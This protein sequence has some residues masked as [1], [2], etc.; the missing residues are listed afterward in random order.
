MTVRVILVADGDTDYA[1]M[2]KAKAEDTD[3]SSLPL[4]FLRPEAVGLRRRA[5]GG[6]NTLIREAGLAAIMAAKGHAD[7]VMVL[8]DNDGDSR[9]SFPH[10]NGCPGCRECDARNALERIYWGPPFKRAAA[11]VFQ[12]AETLLLSARSGFTPQIEA[13]C[14]GKRLKTLLY[15]REIDDSREMYEAFLAELNRTHVPA[16]RARCYPRIKRMLHEFCS[17]G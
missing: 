17:A 2:E 3:L 8:V 15:G 13:E 12:A 6:H 5:G 10:D 16:I 7:C 11:I 1:F 4:E 9:F 14:F